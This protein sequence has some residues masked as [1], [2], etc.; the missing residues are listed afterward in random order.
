MS[1]KRNVMGV[2]LSVADH[3][4]LAYREEKMSAY[5]IVEPESGCRGISGERAPGSEGSFARKHLD[6]VEHLGVSIGGIGPAYAH[7]AR[8][9]TA[10]R[11][12]TTRHKKKTKKKKKK[13]KTAAPAESDSTTRAATRFWDGCPA[14]NLSTV[15]P[16][17]PGRRPRVIAL[18]SRSH[19]T[20]GEGR[21]R[22]HRSG[23]TERGVRSRATTG[24][25]QRL[26]AGTSWRRYDRKQGVRRRARRPTEQPTVEVLMCGGG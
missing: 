8:I 16:S 7:R 17:K 10:N 22:T 5:A 4:T 2:A 3:T 6:S 9:A 26:H 20:A 24:S 14:S 21:P 25:L 11:R 18:G 19:R 12:S 23:S 13:Q 1:C 15:R